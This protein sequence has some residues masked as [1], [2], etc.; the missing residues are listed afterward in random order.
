MQLANKSSSSALVLS[1]D[2]I[3]R[4]L[5]EELKDLLAASL[6]SAVAPSLLAPPIFSE[7]PVEDPDDPDLPTAEGLGRC[8][9]KE[10]G[11]ETVAL[12]ILLARD[13]TGTPSV[14]T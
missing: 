13:C 3:D 1:R 2:S 6:V 14:R 10:P 8:D 5:S 9:W 4:E 12:L 7:G 11:D